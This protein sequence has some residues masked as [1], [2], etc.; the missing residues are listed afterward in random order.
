MYYLGIAVDASKREVR[1]VGLPAADPAAMP[2]LRTLTYGEDDLP[3]R[4]RDLHAAT[5][6]TLGELPAIAAAVRRMDPPPPRQ[7]AAV[8]T[9]TIDR[10]LAE[11]AVLA[12]VR[13]K[14]EN[15]VHLTGNEAASRLGFSTKDD[16]LDAA[17]QFL[18]GHKQV[19][20]WAEATMVAQTLV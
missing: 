4:M 19:K 18:A 1:F 12:A 13:D 5:C 8:R 15:V 7:S 20:K 17:K 2:E 3:T 6:S 16:A 10:L 11:G 14:T 9:A